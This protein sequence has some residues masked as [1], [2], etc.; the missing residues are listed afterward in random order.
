M[1]KHRYLTS[2]LCYSLILFICY[3]SVSNAAPQSL[4]SIYQQAVAN[5]PQLA[6]AKKSNQAVQENIVQAQALNR[7]QVDLNAGIQASRNDIRFIGNAPFAEGGNAFEGYQYGISARQPLYRKQNQLLVEQSKLQVQQAD[8]QWLLAQQQLMFDTTQAYS[9]VLIASASV[10]QLDAQKTAIKQQLAQAKANFDVGNATITDVNEAQARRDLV[11]AQSI[12]ANNQYQVALHAV[13]VL[14]GLQPER[15][16]HFKPTL[17]IKPLADNMQQ[18]V[19]RALAHNLAVQSQQDALAI[20]DKNIKRSRAGL[21]PTIDGVAGYNKSY[22]NGGNFGFGQ[23]LDSFVLGVQFAMPLYHGGEIRSRTRQAVI[24]QAKTE[25]DLAAAKR[26]ITLATQQAYLT[27]ESNLAEI[28]AL[29][30]ALVS[31]QSQLDATKTGYAVGIRTSVDVLNALQ[32]HYA[33][34]RDVAIAHYRYLTH[35]V[36]LKT[37]AGTLVLAN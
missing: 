14:T 23:S 9:N 21:Y 17:E 4:Y 34:K 12:A 3:V 13:E 35:W 24:Q 29:K 10:D 33:A 31:S 22:Q 20:A 25:Q 2:Q 16:I 1:T 28:E 8:K 19:E 27:V 30:A 15:L 36:Q 32:Q 5:D 11:N 26:Q 7:T 37:I 18:W 6:A